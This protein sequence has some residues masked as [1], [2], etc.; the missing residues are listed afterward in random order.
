[1]RKIAVVGAGT[2]GTSIAEMIAG[3]GYDVVLFDIQNK[4]VETARHNIHAQLNRLIQKEKLSESE[5]D[6]IVR[7]I[8][9]TT[10]WESLREADYVTEAI[11]EK[12]ILKQ[13][14]YRKL[15][16]ICK[17]EVVFATNTSGLSITEIASVLTCPER[18]IGTH[19]FYPVPKMKLVEVVRGFQTS[20]QTR[21]IAVRFL[22]RMGKQVI[23]V[24]E[25]PLFVVNRL[26]IPMINEAIFVLQEGISSKEDIDQAM[27]LG[28]GHQIGPLALADV[29][30]LDTLLYVVETIFEETGDPKYRPA[31]LLKQMV[32]AGHLGRKTKRGFYEYKIML[33]NA[34]SMVTAQ[35]MKNKP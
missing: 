35:D 20:D 11:P 33:Q 34:E 27:R 30:G 3:A 17:E 23:E 12:T 7:R 28:A 9:L 2:M 21:D 18:M 4:H 29:I 16:K 6:E 5:R 10:E 32:R 13:E 1:M 8:V 14:L 22:E 26:L 31:P 24:K 15:E 25:S 19:Y